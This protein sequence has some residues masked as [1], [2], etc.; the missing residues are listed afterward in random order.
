MVGDGLWARLLMTHLHAHRGGE[1]RWWEMVGDGGRDAPGVDVVDRAR[2]HAHSEMAGDGGR[3][4]GRRTGS[5]YCRPPSSPAPAA[6]SR[7]R[8]R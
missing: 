4:R 2:M 3:W 6:V 8:P 5:E 1:G 7:R